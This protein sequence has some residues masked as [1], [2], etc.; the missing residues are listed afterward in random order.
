MLQM[1]LCTNVLLK[2]V[3]NVLRLSTLEDDDNM[4]NG[5]QWASPKVELSSETMTFESCKVL[6]DD[7]I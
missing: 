1:T 2:Y 7:I 6:I 4:F 5:F 3:S